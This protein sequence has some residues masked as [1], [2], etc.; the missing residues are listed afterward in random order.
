MSRPG[1]V[2][3]A[4]GYLLKVVLVA[5]AVIIVTGFLRGNDWVTARLLPVLATIGWALLALD[6]LVLLPLSAARTLRPHAGAAIHLSARLLGLTAWL[7]GFSLTYAIWGT[8][9]AVAGL[10]VIGV[11]VVPMGLLATLTSGLLA[12]FLDLLVFVAATFGAWKG[13]LV[14]AGA[15]AVKPDAAVPAET[16]PAP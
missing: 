2:K 11:G 16:P 7:V 14:I 10:L 8:L 1:W 4:G 5:G 9:A 12:Q 3:P 6:L 15:S 13:G